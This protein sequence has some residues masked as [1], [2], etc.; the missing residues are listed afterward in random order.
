MQSPLDNNL[1]VA[2]K[3]L[4]VL[5]R[6]LIKSSMDQRYG[7]AYAAL[8]RSADLFNGKDEIA[9]EQNLVHPRPVSNLIAFHVNAP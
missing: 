9:V 3:F 2:H 7:D 8:C 6:Q 5:A 4:G 1:R